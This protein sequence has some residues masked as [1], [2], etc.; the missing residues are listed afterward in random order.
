MRILYLVHQFYPQTF[1]GTEKFLLRLAQSCQAAGHTVA[2]VTYDPPAPTVTPYRRFVGPAGRQILRRLNAW[3][4]NLY[5]WL[6]RRNATR[7]AAAHRIQ[8]RRYTY[9]GLPVIAYRRRPVAAAPA[10]T[11]R[12]LLPDFVAE[13]L[14]EIQP[15]LIHAAHVMR[16][17]DF[18]QVAVDQGAPNLLTLTD[19]W[20]ICPN[21]RL[22]TERNER[23]WGPQ[24]GRVCRR[25]C[26]SFHP[27]DIAERLQR[28]GRLLRSARAIV[29]PTRF[30]AERIQAEHGSLPIQIIPYGMDSDP[31]P[32]GERSSPRPLVFAFAGM[33]YEAKGIELLIAAFRRLAAPDVRLVIYGGG[34]LETRLRKQ[35]AGDARIHFGGVYA[36]EELGVRLSQI[37]VLVVPSLWHE[38]APLVMLEALAHGVPVLVSDVPGMTECVTDG[39]NGL[40]FRVGDVDD[41]HR[42]LQW[43]V[44]Q[45]D[46]LNPIVAHLR[47]PRPGQYCIASV[48]AT[49]AR[50]L[51]LYA[52][53]VNAAHARQIAR[54]TQ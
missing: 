13:V 24:G 48:A 37:D 42:K 36:P 1:A 4:I 54:G 40:T 44:S 25:S 6:P 29:A 49:G 31:R 46:V 22:Q 45:P 9:A 23:C 47:Q 2:I 41:L 53:C 43:I 52:D 18:L 3:G 8:Q 30:L 26:P 39:V 15:D 10:A 34:R 32:S 38:N 27:A 51:D 14:R 11:G 17:E 33:L 7:P 5:R 19:F 12:P 20:L 16:V 50:Y 28:A 21:C 35:A